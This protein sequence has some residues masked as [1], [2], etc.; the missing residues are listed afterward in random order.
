MTNSCRALRIAEQIRYDI[1]QAIDRHPF[2][3]EFRSRRLN[4]AELRRFASQWYLTVKAQ[5]AFPSYSTDDAMRSK[6]INILSEYH[7]TGAS[8]N[9]SARLLTRF[10]ASLDLCAADYDDDAQRIDA[11]RHFAESTRAL[12]THSSHAA[13][14]GVHFALAVAATLMHDAFAQGVIR[15]GVRADGEY[16]WYHQTAEPQHPDSLTDAFACITDISVSPDDVRTG[17]TAA[18]WQILA[19]LD[20]LYL[21]TFAEQ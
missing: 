7:G 21:A 4:V 2:L 3:E 10:L 6:I 18:K 11:V 15:S 14:F 1:W 5:R 19:L 20:G 8:M 9:V 17:A 12:W 13:A 16:F